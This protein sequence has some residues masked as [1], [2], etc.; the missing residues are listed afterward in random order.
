MP[1]KMNKRTLKR[2]RKKQTRLQFGGASENPRL[3]TIVRNLDT[4]VRNNEER[5]KTLKLFTRLDSDQKQYLS[6]KIAGVAESIKSVK[7]ENN[8]TLKLEKLTKLKELNNDVKEEFEAAAQINTIMEHIKRMEEDNEK[9]KSKL[10]SFKYLSKG[11]KKEREGLISDM[12]IIIQSTLSSL[13]EGR[14][15]TDMLKE[16]KQ[17]KDLLN[18]MIEEASKANDKRAKEDAKAAAQAQAARKAEEDAAAAAAAYRQY[19]AA[20]SATEQAAPAT[21]QTAALSPAAA[22]AATRTE[23]EDAEEAAARKAEE[24]LFSQ[25]WTK[26]MKASNNLGMVLGGFLGIP[27]GIAFSL[28]PLQWVRK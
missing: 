6:N 22:E 15:I 4:I 28:F 1:R 9:R 12:N 18:K 13:K 17:G 2:K 23:K 24:E 25:K 20:S 14:D 27:V 21:G 16:L 7:E 5:E 26:E 11:E 10:K 3:D 8:T 19:E